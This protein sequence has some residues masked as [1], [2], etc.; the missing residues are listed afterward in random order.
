MALKLPLKYCLKLFSSFLSLWAWSYKFSS[1][2]KHNCIVVVLKI[3]CAKWIS[4]RFLVMFF[5]VGN[6][7]FGLSTTVQTISLITDNVGLLIILLF[8]QLG[9]TLC[10]CFCQPTQPAT[11]TAQRTHKA[12]VKRASSDNSFDQSLHSNEVSLMEVWS[13]TQQQMSPWVWLMRYFLTNRRISLLIETDWL[14]SFA[15][16]YTL[17][18]VFV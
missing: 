15:Y 11:W 2:S 17:E 3:R 12:T 14:L 7:A 18:Q 1:T 9:I 5:Q 6:L 4:T 10:N 8:A 16:Y 13:N